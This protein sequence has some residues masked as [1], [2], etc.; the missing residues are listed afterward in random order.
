MYLSEIF[1][2]LLADFWRDPAH[3]N[4]NLAVSCRELFLL[5]PFLHLLLCIP[6]VFQVSQSDN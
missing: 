1:E 2:S 3:I 5:L 4:T 6:S